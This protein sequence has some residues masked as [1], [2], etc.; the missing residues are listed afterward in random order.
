MRPNST[1]LNQQPCISRRPD[2]S[3]Q[4]RLALPA[5]YSNILFRTLALIVQMAVVTMLEVLC[6]APM[7][8]NRIAVSVP[9]SRFPLFPYRTAP[10]HTCS[11]SRG[12]RC[13]THRTGR[14]KAVL[15][16][17]VVPIVL[18]RTWV[19]R[20]TSLTVVELQPRQADPASGAHISTSKC[21]QGGTCN[22]PS[23]FRTP[24][25]GRN[26]CTKSSR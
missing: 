18:P 6:K 15:L 16:P 8:P 12:Q 13:H 21:G 14:G 4:D 23:H 3:H 11:A 17:N 25:A 1:L 22:A 20:Q 7:F 19:R 24:D 2:A 9:H 26:A 10:E 5:L